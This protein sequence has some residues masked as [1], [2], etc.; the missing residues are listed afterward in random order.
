M[1]R[2][3]LTRKLGEKIIIN[4]NIIIKVVA[5]GEHRVRLS[6][7]ADKTIPIDREEV[8]EQKTHPDA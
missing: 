6:V 2:L 5:L 1:G 3:V 8:E 7:E 4:H